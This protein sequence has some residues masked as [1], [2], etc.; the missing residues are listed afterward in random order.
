MNIRSILKYL[1][2][3]SAQEVDWDVRNAGKRAS[4]WRAF[5]L[6]LSGLE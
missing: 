6:D 4:A 5:T 3:D 1:Y 2:L